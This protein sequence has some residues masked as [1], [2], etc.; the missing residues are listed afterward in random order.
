MRGVS[1]TTKCIVF[2][3][4]PAYPGWLTYVEMLLDA[5]NECVW[6]TPWR[7]AM[8]DAANN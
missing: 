6:H 1:Y 5:R 4:A 7:E 3:D 2:W 8:A